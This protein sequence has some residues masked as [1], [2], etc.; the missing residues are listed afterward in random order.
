MKLQ[1]YFLNDIYYCYIYTIYINWRT[2][3]K[4]KEYYINVM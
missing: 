4:Q 3:N 2:Q 1:N